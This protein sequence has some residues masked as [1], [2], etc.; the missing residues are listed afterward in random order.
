[1]TK[2]TVRPI[3]NQIYYTITESANLTWLNA[4]FIATRD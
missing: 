4:R 2:V 3:S 1:V